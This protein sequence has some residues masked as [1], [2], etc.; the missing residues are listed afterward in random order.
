MRY[1][2]TIKCNAYFFARDKLLPV[3]WVVAMEDNS[4]LL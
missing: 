3:G 4:S 2:T 1:R